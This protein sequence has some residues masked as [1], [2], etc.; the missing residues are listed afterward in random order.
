VAALTD[1]GCKRERNEDAFGLFRNELGTKTAHPS[2]GCLLV[3]ADGMG[4]AAAGEVASTLAVEMLRESYFGNDEPVPRGEALQESMRLTNELIHWRSTAETEL[5]GMG[6]TC[7]AAAIAGSELHVGHVGD[8]RAYL[9]R[10]DTV[11]TLTQDHTVAAQ[12]QM[13]GAPASART[14]C[15]LTRCLGAQTA[16]EVDLTRPVRL[17]PGDLILLCSDGLWGQVDLHEL[18]DVVQSETP[19]LACTTLVERARERG[20]PDNITVVVAR[21]QAA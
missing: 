12:L 21:V 11:E 16:V 10:H 19:E 17:E 8:S 6:T 15:M 4:G 18:R 20:G 2:R 1:V 5:R 14:Q 13:A 7:T 3:V 9:F